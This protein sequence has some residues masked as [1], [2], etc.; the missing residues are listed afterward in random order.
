[1]SIKV[2]SFLFGNGSSQ[3]ANDLKKL[4]FIIQRMLRGIF[5]LIERNL[6]LEQHRNI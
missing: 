4:K 2:E 1:M 6:A 5:I 3:L